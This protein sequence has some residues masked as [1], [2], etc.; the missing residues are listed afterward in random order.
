MYRI[1]WPALAFGCAALL[2]GQNPQRLDIKTG[3][4]KS[5][6]TSQ[7]SGTPPIPPEALAQL[8]PEQRAKIEERM[9]ASM[10]APQTH[11]GQ[12]CIKEEDL[13]KFNFGRNDKSCR[14][15]FLNSSSTVQEVRLNCDTGNMKT[16]GTIHIEALSKENVKGSGKM[17][18]TD[19][20]H[21]MN[22]NM[23]FAGTWVAPTCTDADN[24]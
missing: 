14:Q 18:M 23:S 4:W 8:T 10:A 13:D 11:T 12:H 24:K 19:G 15:T 16:S 2:A 17:T 3:L 22:V 9:K 5:T 7:T 21:T 20:T 1:L 6:V